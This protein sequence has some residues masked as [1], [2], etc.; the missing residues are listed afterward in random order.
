VESKKFYLI[1]TAIVVGVIGFALYTK[2]N[3]EAAETAANGGAKIS[4]NYYGKL[5][6]P[7][8]LTEF[9]DFQCEACYAYYPMVKEVKE[10]YKDKVKFQIRNFPITSGHKFA[11]QAARTAEAAARQGKFWEMH[12]LIFENQ[13]SWEQMVDPQPVFDGY[14]EQIGLD[15]TKF[16][17]D[18]ASGDVASVINQDLKDVKESGG[19]GTPTFWLNG[20]RIEKNPQSVEEFKTLLDEAL[21]TAGVQ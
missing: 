11:M 3:R 15:M 8:T 5:D 12:D 19:T 14:A 18:F 9:V 13:K 4:S 1:L 2:N 16:K 6:S 7:V 21:K 17:E 10:L 20:E